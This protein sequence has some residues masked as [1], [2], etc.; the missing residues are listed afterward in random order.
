MGTPHLQAKN[1]I[2]ACIIFTQA[3]LFGVVSATTGISALASHIPPLPSIW[4]NYLLCFLV[5]GPD[6]WRHFILWLLVENCCLAFTRVL[7][8]AFVHDL[9]HI[10]DYL[11]PRALSF[12]TSGSIWRLIVLK[13]PRCV[14]T[15]ICCTR[16][17]FIAH[18]IC[19]DITSALPIIT[20]AHRFII[21]RLVSAWWWLSLCVIIDWRHGLSLLFT[22][23]I[24]IIINVITSIRFSYIGVNWTDWRL[25]GAAVIP[26]LP[27]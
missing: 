18:E 10:D 22:H 6:A 11:L 2:K 3:N 12:A 23:E 25:G 20:S 15:N 1:R 17:F 7:S 14:S 16:A 24:R 27:K 5:G 8:L 19:T 4:T 9:A 26:L 21:L 13:P